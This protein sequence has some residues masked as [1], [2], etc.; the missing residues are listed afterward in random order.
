M[1]AYK[2]EPESLQRYLV[3]RAQGMTSEGLVQVVV[4]VLT[5]NS[6]REL[7]VVMSKTDA[8]LLSTQLQSVAIEVQKTVT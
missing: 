5:T 1:P 6:G 2:S 3:D 4:L 7:A 8:M